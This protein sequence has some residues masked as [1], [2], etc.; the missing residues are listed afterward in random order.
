MGASLH[1]D[2]SDLADDAPDGDEG[3][4]AEEEP[5][6]RRLHLSHAGHARKQE[7]RKSLLHDQYHKIIDS[8]DQHQ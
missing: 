4:A 7:G 1:D 3:V 6:Q 8:L 2:Q 5:R